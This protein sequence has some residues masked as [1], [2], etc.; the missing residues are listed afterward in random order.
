MSATSA[1]AAFVLPMTAAAAVVVTTTTRVF[2]SFIE[3]RF[4]HLARISDD[5]FS[6]DSTTLLLL[7]SVQ[8]MGVHVE[9][10]NN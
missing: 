2:A 6:G 5:G 3:N 10:R 4:T 1:T 9:R 8:Q 7:L